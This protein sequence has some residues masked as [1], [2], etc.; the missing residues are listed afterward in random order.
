[1]K[2]IFFC[3]ILLIFIVSCGDDATPVNASAVRFSNGLLDITFGTSGTTHIDFGG[4]DYGRSLA[5]DSSNNVYICG[6]TDKNADHDFAIT[7]IKYNGDV[8]TTFGASGKVVTDFGSGN[9][10]CNELIIDSSGKI[11]AV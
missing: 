3:I 7:K 2:R 11:M 8:D 10:H 4:N 5:V 6:Y 1:M 9:D